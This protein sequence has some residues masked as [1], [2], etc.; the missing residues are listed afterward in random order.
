MRLPVN[1][2][3]PFAALTLLAA[4][5]GGSHF[6]DVGPLATTG[7]AAD[8]PMVLG[9]P[10]TVDGITY[11]PSDALNYDAVGFAASAAEDGDSVSGAHRTLPLPSYA[12]V[13]SLENG[14]TILVRIERRGPMTGSQLIELSRGAVNQLGLVDQTKPAVRVRRV[15]PPEIERAMLRGGHAAPARMNTPK[16]LLAVL[17][18]K[19]DQQMGVT[20]PAPLPIPDS[21]PSPVANRAPASNPAPKPNEPKAGPAL[22]EAIK[23]GETSGLAVQV[24]AFASKT[25]AET[26]AK[27]LGGQVSQS[28]RLWRVQMGPYT[29]EG[30]ARAALA[31]ARAAGYGDA[32]IQRRS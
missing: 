3:L 1:R 12:E 30:Q 29:S 20:T 8:Y 21:L 28:G 25:N 5:G 19:L 18:R 14:K 15:N 11:S 9:A 32:R 22:K 31:K 23:P 27:K 24:G 7:P 2:S 17:Q 4:C 10:F 6:N 26:L 13:T 16:S